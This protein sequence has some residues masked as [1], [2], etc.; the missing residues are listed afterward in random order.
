MGGKGPA[1]ELFGGMF[2]RANCPSRNIRGNIY[3]ET[4]QEGKWAEK[5]SGD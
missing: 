4:V 5:L 1:E 3:A 2:E